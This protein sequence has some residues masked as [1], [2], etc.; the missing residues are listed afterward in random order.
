MKVEIRLRLAVRRFAA[1]RH[2]ADAVARRAEAGLATRVE[3]LLAELRANQAVPQA[4]GGVIRKRPFTRTEGEDACQI[5]YAA[6]CLRLSD[7][8]SRDSR[9][10]WIGLI[11]ARIG[12]SVT[13]TNVDAE[14]FW[15]TLAP[16]EVLRAPATDRSCG[17]SGEKA[18]LILA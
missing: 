10:Q 18:P 9:E 17:L 14:R 12:S 11:R 15:H 13:L 4:A 1:L 6:C 3:E 2:A 8:G 5:T 7:C 16:D